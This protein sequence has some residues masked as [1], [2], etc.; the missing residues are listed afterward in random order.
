M[1]MLFFTIPKI[2]FIIFSNPVCSGKMTQSSKYE[3]KT[4]YEYDGSRHADEIA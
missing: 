1:I 3:F 2:K 4:H